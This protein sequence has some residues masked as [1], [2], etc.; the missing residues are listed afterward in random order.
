MLGT[1]VDKRLSGRGAC[2]WDLDGLAI[3]TIDG[4]VTVTSTLVIIRRV[5]LREARQSSPVGFFPAT[6]PRSGTSVG[7][8][9]RFTGTDETTVIRMA[10]RIAVENF[11]R[12]ILG[13]EKSVDR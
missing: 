4:T 3:R 12:E 2:T 10:E 9:S 7:S 6:A 1:H 13:L 11:I 8:T 5:L